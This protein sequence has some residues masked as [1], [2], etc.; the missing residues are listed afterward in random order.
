MMAEV[1]IGGVLIAPIVIY[2]LI[3]LAIFAVCRL[4]LG[5]FDL[6]RRVWHPA[7]FEVALFLCILSLL[8]L[9]L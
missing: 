3:A 6:L 5:H 1:N 2:M 7:L 9:Y 8:F 4:A